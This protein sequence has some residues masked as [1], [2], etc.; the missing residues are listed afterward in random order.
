MSDPR[1]RQP[2]P[3]ADDSPEVETQV[4]ADLDQPSNEADD[5]RG[6]CLRSLPTGCMHSGGK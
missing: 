4:I 5:I 2:E 1:E 3:A 6:G